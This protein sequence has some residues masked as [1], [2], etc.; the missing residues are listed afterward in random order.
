MINLELYKVFYYAA[1]TG[2]ISNAAKELFI[3]QP[4]VSQSIK[5]L[6]TELGGKV[7]FRTPRGIKLT[8]EGK[9][10]Y[11][12]I[13][14]AYGLIRTAENKFLEMQS[15]MSG[16][17]KV[18]AGDTLSKYYLLPYL[19]EFHE[20]YSQVKVQV[21][22]RTTFE[23]IEL[24]KSGKVDFGIINLPIKKS[25]RLVIHE[26][27]TV[28]DCFVCGEKYRDLA[29]NPISVKDL[30]NYPLLLLEKGS[31]T[32]EFIDNF[33]LE[34]NVEVVPEIEL[35]SVNLLI[36]FAKIGLGISCVVKDFIEDELKNG[37]FFEI[38][39][40][41][42]IPKRKIGVIT[43]KDVPLSSSAKEFLRMLNMKE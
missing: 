26:V 17:I 4:A 16:E 28:E 11:K 33:F 20:K 6:E 18:G 19:R 23:T 39:L 35:G 31:N 30:L 27:L 1:K 10:L 34:H 9:V 13:E 8:S 42:K 5:Q 15:L 37:E 22:N 36:E 43:L 38:E 2:S 21:T 7:F 24:L 25:D 12:Y 41:E 40:L 29:Q 3:T 14:Q 32:R